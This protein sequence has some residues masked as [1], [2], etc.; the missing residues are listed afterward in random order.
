MVV[1]FVQ[2]RNEEM[3]ILSHEIGGLCLRSRLCVPSLLRM[4]AKI[5]DDC[6]DGTA[7]E[8]YPV[9]FQQE[10]WNAS[11]RN[12]CSRKDPGIFDG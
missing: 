1:Q 4:V 8:A 5:D 11:E 3:R 10:Y 9:E 7:S 2:R 12:E 6:R